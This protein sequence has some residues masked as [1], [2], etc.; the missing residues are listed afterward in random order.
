MSTTVKPWRQSRR[1]KDL[2]DIDD[3]ELLYLQGLTRCNLCDLSYPRLL[4]NCPHC[5]SKSI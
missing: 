4:E 5:K 2:D 1:K 3:D